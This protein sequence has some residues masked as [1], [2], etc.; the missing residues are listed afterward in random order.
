MSSPT[1]IGA[2]IAFFVVAA[3]LYLKTVEGFNNPEQVPAD[4][5]RAIVSRP[6][7]TIPSSTQPKP[8]GIPGPMTAPKEALATRNELA[9][10]DSKIMTWLAAASQRELENPAALTADQ[11]Q[12]RVEYQ[13]RLS[14]IRQQ[15]GTGIITDKSKAIST[16]ILAIRNAN[17]GWQQ[18]YPNLLAA[19]EFGLGSSPDS[20]VTAEQYKDFRGLMLV[21]LNEL[22]GFTQP[23]PLQLA[24][25]K[26]LEQIDMELRVVDHKQRIPAIRVGAAKAFLQKMTEP[27]QP[28]PSLI[29]M[30][31]ENGPQMAMNPT[32][33]I[34][35]VQ[36]IPNPPSQLLDLVTR[37]TSGLASPNQ[38]AQTR[39][40]VTEFAN[41]YTRYDP[42][43]YVER[44]RRLCKQVREAFPNDAEALGCPKHPLTDPVSAETVVYNVCARIRDSVPSVSPD[45]FNCPK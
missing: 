14:K 7:E 13:A 10:L 17:A 5:N 25:L 11:R 42:T 8:P 19:G 30:D 31:S 27:A 9:E 44:A 40:V 26:Q 34:R 20:F 23:D 4:L 28:L 6:L 18:V 33:I 22:K 12:Q 2:A 15:L 41:S 24:R 39:N 43:D 37:V 36:T 38:V 21:T 29:S 45:Q 1:L 35:Q 3:L 16:E 32:D